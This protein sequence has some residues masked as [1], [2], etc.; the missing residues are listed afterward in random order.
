MQKCCTVGGPVAPLPLL[1][2]SRESPFSSHLSPKN[3]QKIQEK[4][5]GVRRI[6]AAKP[7]RIAA[8]SSSGERGFDDEKAAIRQGFAA[9]LLLTPLFFSRFLV[10][11]LGRG[12]RPPKSQSPAGEGDRYPHSATF[13][14]KDL[15][16]K[17][18]TNRSCRLLHGRQA[19]IFEILKNNIYF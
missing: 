12:D 14:H 18:I 4:N 17:K 16:V 3:S 5:R 9:S 6:E 8:F 13:L 10:D 15:F 19:L 2:I 11:F 1:Y 7:C